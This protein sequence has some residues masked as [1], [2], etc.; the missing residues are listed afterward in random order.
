MVELAQELVER[1]IDECWSLVGSREKSMKYHHFSMVSLDRRKLRSFV[2]LMESSPLPLLSFIRNLSLSLV[3][4]TV[5]EA[6]LLARIHPC[7]N[8]TR[9]GIFVVGNWRGPL[10][11]SW[12]DSNQSLHAHLRAWHDESPTLSCLDLKVY[13]YTTPTIPL[14][15]I[16]NIIS[17]VPGIK[18]LRMVGFVI[19]ASTD[20]NPS[21]TL[22]RLETLDLHVSKRADLFFS[23]MQTLPT[24]PA[25]KSLK[26][27]TPLIKNVEWAVVVP[28]FERAGEG[29]QSLELCE[30]SPENLLKFKKQIWR[31]TPNLR[32]IEFSIRDPSK[33]VKFLMILPAS[34]RWNTIDIEFT[35]HGEGI[36][37]RNLD[38]ALADP[39]FLHLTRFTLKLRDFDIPGG[40]PMIT[41]ET[42]FRLPLASA[43]GILD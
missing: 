22:P 41:S 32:N 42:K 3:E 18:S 4:G 29:L 34:L 20:T 11:V 17:C 25:L 36:L 37:W 35:A 33:L 1:I 26:F 38:T 14:R 23:W 9:I 30:V 28:Y 15:T 8:L 21:F 31:Y 27:L 24:L 5:P 43:R 10:L 19:S 16:T 2:K 13:T 39:R 40:K 7:P 6:A 12:L